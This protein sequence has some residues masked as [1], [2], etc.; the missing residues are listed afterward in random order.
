MAI[1]IALLLTTLVLWL[2][3]VFYQKKWMKHLEVSLHFS[4]KGIEEGDECRLVE[5]ICNRKKMPLATLELKFSTDAAL[6]FP[7]MTNAMVTDRYYR[8]DLFSVD[9]FQKITRTMTVKAKKRGY[10][11]IKEL[12][13]ISRD[14]LMRKQYMHRFDNDASLLVYP[15]KCNTNQL[16]MIY[17][18]ILGELHSSYTRNED[19]FAFR[20]MREYMPGDPMRFINWKT[21]AH[22]GK[23]LVN[24][25]E[26]Q[27]TQKVVLLVDEK[28]DARFDME[29]LEEE[30]LVISSS[31][32]AALLQNGVEVAYYTNAKDVLNKEEI[33]IPCNDRRFQARTIDEKLALADLRQPKRPMEEFW[34]MVAMEQG[35]MPIYLLIGS[36]RQKNMIAFT[37]AARKE[38]YC[39]F[40]ILA[41]SRRKKKDL[42]PEGPVRVC[43]NV[44]PWE[45]DGC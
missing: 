3:R 28:V 24:Q 7:D 1:I 26:H 30:L 19:P 29:M 25:F 11:Q 23:I 40:A 16:N 41:Y 2:E 21:S 27:C 10:Y 36:M 43:N 18:E 8:R 42:F 5:E 22:A 6:Q 37:E 39:M 13:G 45:T 34:K 12:D 20:G 38:G 4:E 33:C 35:Q 14:Y 15:R 44:F 32:A 17:R 9:G 31:I